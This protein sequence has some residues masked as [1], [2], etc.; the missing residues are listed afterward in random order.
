MNKQ[1]ASGKRKYLIVTIPQKVQRIRRLESDESCSVIIATQD[2]GLSILIQRN[3]STNLYGA[4]S[5]FEGS[6]K[7]MDIT[8]A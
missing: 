1:G 4:K 3:R 5:K 7:A 2:T 6:A 8:T